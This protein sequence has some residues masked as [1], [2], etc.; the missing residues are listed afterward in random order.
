M[1]NIA[2]KAKRIIQRILYITIA[3]TSKNGQ[4]WNSPVYSAFDENYNFYWA[5]WRENRHSKNIKENN[6]IFLVIYDSTVPEGTGEGVYIQT[7]AYQLEDPKEIENALKYLDG[8]VNKKKDPTTRVAE[9][10]GD[11]PRRIYKAIPEKIWM[12]DVGNVNGNYI[13]KRIEIKL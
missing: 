3:T 8:R 6:N 13:D 12:N 9:F 4:S 7:K 5:S 10:Q 2:E 11:K 1:K